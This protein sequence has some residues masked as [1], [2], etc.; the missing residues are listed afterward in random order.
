MDEQNQSSNKEIL[1]DLLEQD[2]ISEIEA[3]LLVNQLKGGNKNEETNNEIITSEEY[4]I[5]EILNLLKQ[6]IVEGFKLLIKIIQDVSLDKQIINNSILNNND[7]C[8]IAEYKDYGK[9]NLPFNIKLVNKEGGYE[10]EGEYV[11]RVFEILYKLD[12]LGFVKLTGFYNSYDGTEYDDEII[13]VYPK[14]VIVTQYVE[15]LQK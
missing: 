5:E 14:Q 1:M 4:K 13:Q 2:L 3:E 6:N 7:I 8:N 10:G 15:D 9:L 11:E 12:S